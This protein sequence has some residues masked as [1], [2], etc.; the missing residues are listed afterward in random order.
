[1]RLLSS[2]A[3]PALLLA[4]V[5]MLGGCRATAA[6]SLRAPPGFHIELVSSGSR[7][8]LYRSCPERRLDRQR[9][10]TRE[11]GSHTARQRGR[12]GS[13]GDSIRRSAAAWSRLSRRRFVRRDLGRRA[14]RSVFEFEIG[15]A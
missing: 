6:G 3:L 15:R 5:L 12:R 9:N 2:R 14:E 11:G 13:E 8:S 10:R 7:R 1:M 4:L